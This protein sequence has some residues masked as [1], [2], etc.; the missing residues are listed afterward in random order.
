MRES[1]GLSCEAKD[2]LHATV[3]RH[4]SVLLLLRVNIVIV[5]VFTALGKITRTYT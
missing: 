5:S 2:V 4:R 3:S 1:L